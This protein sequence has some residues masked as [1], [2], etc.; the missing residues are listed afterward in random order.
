[1]ERGDQGK[2]RADA[3]GLEARLKVKE[4]KGGSV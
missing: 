1:M 4:L 2:E 3:E